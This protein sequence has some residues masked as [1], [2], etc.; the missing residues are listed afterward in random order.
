MATSM[1]YTTTIVCGSGYAGTLVVTTTSLIT[2]IAYEGEYGHSY[3]FLNH[4]ISELGETGVS[5]LAWLFNLG[6]ILG[7]L[8][9]ATFMVSL[10]LLVRT[11][12]M[13]VIAGIGVVSALGM[14]LVG[15]FPIGP[16]DA[17]GNHTLAAL[18]FF[19]G[20]LVFALAFTI[21]VLASK[22]SPFPKWL[23][24]SSGIAA[25]SF[26]LFLFLPSLVMDVD[27][28]TM[29]EGPSGPDRPTFWLPSFLE[30]MIMFAVVAWIVVTAEVVRRDNLR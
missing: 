3:S 15:V 22:E 10:G 12:P 6:L 20:G 26:V 23:A 30:W 27:R 21:H 1:D 25:A 19:L 18:T 9:F 16:P 13:T 5:Q 28:D 11:R 2:A 24:A 7:G 14:G 8:A 4:N 29:L 17:L